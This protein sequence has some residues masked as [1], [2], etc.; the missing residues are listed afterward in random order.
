MRKQ[1]L[2][3]QDVFVLLAMMTAISSS[4][5]CCCC[6][7]SLVF[8]LHMLPCG[9][10]TFMIPS[11]AQLTTSRKFL[12]SSK[13]IVHHST[14]FRKE[15][16]GHCISKYPYPT[17][18]EGSMKSHL[19]AQVSS[20]DDDDTSSSNNEEAI[21]EQQNNRTFRH[22]N[23]NQRLIGILVL[24]TVP[25]SWGTYAPVVKYVYEMNPPTPGF[26]FSA[27]YYFIASL[28]LVTLS[29]MRSFSNVGYEGAVNQ[30]SLSENLPHGK[31]ENTNNYIQSNN[32]LSWQ[33]SEKTLGGLELGSYLFLGNCLQVV[34]LESIPADRAAFL[35]Q[36]TTIMVPILQATFA[37]DF[38][39]ISSTTWV[40]CILAFAGVIIMGFDRPDLD[41]Q[42]G[43]EMFRSM[44]G[45][46]LHGFSFSGGDSLI[47]IAALCY[48]MHV[49]RLGKYAKVTNPLELAA[50][51][52]TVEA[53]LSVALVL[54]LLA[55]PS[56][57]S[58]IPLFVD[59]ESRDIQT[60]FSQ[61]QYAVDEGTFPPDG[62]LKAIVASLWTGLVTCAYTIY[63]QSFGQRRVD[64][65]D[66][67]LIY[68]MQPVFSA[69]FAWTLLGENLGAFGYAGGTFIGVALWIVTSNKGSRA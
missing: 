11:P 28:T 24:L 15:E 10:A 62:F 58:D 25:L 23:D 16:K 60:Y 54:G 29:S 14:C 19:S 63:A 68:T 20:A 44:S 52:A 48:S 59:N 41:I 36:L 61:L 6:C 30:D 4:C 47:I 3:V 38:S 12:M 56:W 42:I 33:V 13:K 9:A 39:L 26:V 53:V 45:A 66:A 49:I 32:S 37:R 65:T 46:R 50:S 17:L 21:R 69:M 31:E 27:G 1:R 67:N 43:E 22:P 5:S 40:A 51:K 64:P 2:L 55:I 8:A 7:L 34:G 35:V 18:M 57:T